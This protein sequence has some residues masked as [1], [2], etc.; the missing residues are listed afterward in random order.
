MKNVLTTELVPG[1]VAGKDIYNSSNLLVVQQGTVLDVKAITKLMIHGIYSVPVADEIKPVEKPAW[2]ENISYYQKLRN[3]ESFKKFKKKYDDGIVRY[4]GN[5]KQAVEKGK[6]IPEEELLEMAYGILDGGEEKIH[7]FD[8]LQNMRDYD[9]E[10]Y[11]HS[12][13]VALIA[14]QF[15]RWLHWR[16]EDVRELMLCGLMHDIGKIMVPEEIIRKPDKL[17]RVEYTRV[18]EHPVTGARI[19]QKQGMGT[20]I[21]N[22]AFMHHE[23]CDGS[24]Y[25][26]GLKNGEI[27]TFGKIIAIV[28]V[29]EAMTAARV[30]RGPMCPFVVIE[31]FEEEGMQKYAVEFLLPFLEHIGNTYIQNRVRLNNGQEGN[32]IFLNKEK[33]SQPVVKCGKEFVNLMVRRDLDIESFL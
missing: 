3:S 28:D 4:S 19:L 2:D 26:R 17:T 16:E 27:D 10:T 29:Y 5:L 14:A 1:M 18:M 30:Y 9:D 33:L 6:K 22:A 31:L 21:I 25:P 15:A 13:N 12:M 7:I 11:A 23:R 20:H 8:M 24:G 32:I